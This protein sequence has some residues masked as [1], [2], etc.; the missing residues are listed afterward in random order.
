VP[1]ACQPR[2]RK[3]SQELEISSGELVVAV[4]LGGDLVVEGTG[5]QASMQ[6]AD[7]K[8][9]QAGECIVVSGVDD[10]LL[11]IGGT[12]TRQDPRVTS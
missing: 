1:Q 2:L 6:D 7:Q 3:T 4:G 10:A 8:V 5:L 12:G 9:G 11:L